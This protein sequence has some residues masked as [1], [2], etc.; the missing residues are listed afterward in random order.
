MY[1]EYKTNMSNVLTMQSKDSIK[2]RE[3][4]IYIYATIELL[5]TYDYEEKR[6]HWY[7]FTNNSYPMRLYDTISDLLALC[8][9]LWKIFIFRIQMSCY[10]G[11]VCSQK[12]V[13][14][15]S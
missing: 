3:Y 12:P 8:Q 15:F 4:N 6:A 1:V 9:Y 5:S 11:C 14:H 7:S 13:V 10:D 2:L